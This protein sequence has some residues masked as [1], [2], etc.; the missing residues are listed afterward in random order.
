MSPE[1][2]EPEPE[3]NLTPRTEAKFNKIEDDFQ[4]ML[5]RNQMAQASARGLGTNS[6]GG[7]G[8]AGD[9]SIPV[10]VPVP[11]GAYGTDSAMFKASPQVSHATISPRP[12]SSEPDTGSFCEYEGYFEENLK[13]NFLILSIN[14]QFAV[15]QQGSILEM[16]N[17]YPPSTSPL[18]AGSPSPGPSPNSLG[19]HHLHNKRKS[20]FA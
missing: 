10:T 13:N 17:G 5:Q 8:S 6:I 7:A 15:F 12:S 18:A 16:S 4:T 11:G 9:Y 20:G 14:S 3:F 1:A 2:E 19:A